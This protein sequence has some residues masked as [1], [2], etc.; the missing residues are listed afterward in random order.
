MQSSTT[1]RNCGCGQ[2]ELCFN[3]AKNKNWKNIVRSCYDA[4]SLQGGLYSFAC[5]VQES[6][7]RLLVQPVR[8]PRS[9]YFL[10]GSDQGPYRGYTGQFI[11]WRGVNIHAQQLPLYVRPRRPH[12]IGFGDL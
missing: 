9:D 2:H 7:L 11:A 6:R 4:A 10:V 5:L 3:K 12:L 1:Y 8:V